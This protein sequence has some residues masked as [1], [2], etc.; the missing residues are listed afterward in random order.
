MKRKQYRQLAALIVPLSMVVL[1]STCPAPFT[2]ADLD[3]LED[4][5]GPQLILEEP[6]E[7]ALFQD[8]IGISGSALDLDAKGL[9]RPLADKAAIPAL[10]W[11][12]QGKE[13]SG[14]TPVESNGSFSLEI[15]TDTYTGNISLVLTAI[16]LNQNKTTVTR[17]L[18][19][20]A[21]GPV[22]TIETPVD[23][24]V[25][26][27]IVMV[28]GSV[29]NSDGS[30]PTNVASVEY[31]VLNTLITG[32]LSD[33]IDPVTGGFSFQFDTTNLSGSI[34][35][36][37][38][39]TDKQGDKTS[40]IRQVSSDLIGPAI[41]I[42]SPAD[43]SIF[44]SGIIVTGSVAN[45]EEDE[46]LDEVVSLVYSTT[47]SIQTTVVPFDPADG[48][49][50]FNLD[51][52][53]IKTDI[54]ITLIAVDIHGHA[55]TRS[56]TLKN[57]GL[58]P[59]LLIASPV[60]GYYSTCIQLS[61]RVQNGPDD[62]G[63]GEVDLSSVSYRIPGTIVGGTLAIN[64]EAGE[65]NFHTQIDTSQ[66]STNVVLEVT[67]LD[68][69]GNESLV[70][71]NLL[72]PAGGGSINVRAGIQNGGISFS[73][74]PVPGASSYRM[75][76]FVFGGIRDSI[77]LGSGGTYVWS[78]L[79][80]GTFHEFQLSATVP[81]YETAVSADLVLAPMS[82]MTFRPWAVN[83][84]YGT[85]RM[86]WTPSL[87]PG[88][89]YLLER[90]VNSGNWEALTVTTAS[91]Y[92]DADV[93]KTNSYRYRLTLRNNGSSSLNESMAS[94]VFRSPYFT[95]KPRV[96]RKTGGRTFNT[97]DIYGDQ[98]IA[99]D[100]TSRLHFFS[101]ENPYQPILKASLNATGER[102]HIAG[103]SAFGF[104]PGYATIVIVDLDTSTAVSSFTLPA[105]EANRNI[106]GLTSTDTRLYIA[107]ADNMKV[108]PG[109]IY[110]YDISLPSAPVLLGSF[111]S[112][113]LG[114]L[115]H[116]DH[117]FIA[118]RFFDESTER[119]KCKLMTA[120][121]SDPSNVVVTDT[122]LLHENN[123]L[124]P[125]H[126]ALSGNYLFLRDN[127]T[128]MRAYNVSNPTAPFEVANGG[129]GLYGQGT[130][131]ITGTTMY[132]ADAYFGG[133]NVYDISAI[134]NGDEDADGA[135]NNRVHFSYRFD[136]DTNT[137]DLIVDSGIMWTAQYDEGI[138][139]IDI[140]PPSS[141][142]EIG[143]LM[144]SGG[145]GDT[146]D[147]L[148]DGERLLVLSGETSM[149]TSGNFH[150]LDV[151]NPTLPS[152]LS[153]LPLVRSS[154]SDMVLAGDTVILASTMT[155]DTSPSGP[156]T[157][158]YGLYTILDRPWKICLLGD[159]AVLGTTASDGITLIDVSKPAEPAKIGSVYQ[160]GIQAV[161]AYGNLI[162]SAKFNEVAL[163][164]IADRATPVLR[165]SVSKNVDIYDIAISRETLF[166]LDGYYIRVFNINPLNGSLSEQLAQAYYCGP[167]FLPHEIL[168]QGDYILLRSRNG[169]DTKL[170]LLDAS[171]LSSI[172]EAAT[173][174]LANLD[175]D[176]MEWSA[177]LVYLGDNSNRKVVVCKIE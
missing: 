57:D 176:C 168:V 85:I 81:G 137:Y 88:A 66:L 34:L 136:L 154:W 7:G 16:D 22:V 47:N 31:E 40:I 77:N 27:K 91:R 76:E 139:V 105:W 113:P 23:R 39:A 115:A 58:G 140:D 30:A 162:L 33:L 149:A 86:E 175:T 169:T 157:I 134:L 14:T 45:S 153:H 64:E 67:A 112:E 101:L 87:T 82:P 151:G 72:K 73:W 117:V 61:G 110:I 119:W 17:R 19:Y 18:L 51:A 68:R 125:E 28:E 173:L 143:S 142:A 108:N 32:D 62:T 3:I 8:T 36:R 75:E 148:A 138:Y 11:S 1:F 141:I 89:R 42:S 9:V 80:N 43:Y 118:H 164:D 170:A 131:F 166:V 46:G 104:S 165:D 103:S 94:M 60:D 56:L 155:I 114:L 174:T 44:A 37:I 83:S 4:R 107:V 158:G 26:G 147:L 145:A 52:T 79:R 74:D 135:I 54:V 159:C 35:I 146:N 111:A 69:N 15:P 161:E 152:E 133:V 63:L 116:N 172:S 13:D 90:Q 124:G 167:A 2:L 122:G 50:T 24:S 97:V 29:R 48:S 96:A 128:G 150:I 126:M 71:V 10:H 55:S 177:N 59:Y 93:I 102:F 160:G 120:E 130:I 171:D 163:I 5:Q 92:S 129:N 156:A 78:G 25:I 106:Y 84:G 41:L 95:N 132:I 53:G 127:G 144:L 49:F 65:D 99:S 12:I 100:Y 121:V 6:V 38:T 20:D 21:T 98:L 123:N 70:R 109:V